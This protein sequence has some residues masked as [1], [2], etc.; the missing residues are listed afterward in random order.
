MKVTQRLSWAILAVAGL[1]LIGHFIWH[2]STWPF[3]VLTIVVVILNA[4]GNLRNV[5]NRHP[6]ENDPNRR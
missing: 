4:L 5:Q 3:S 1:G 2:Y 6:Q